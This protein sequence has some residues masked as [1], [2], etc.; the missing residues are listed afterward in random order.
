MARRRA[1]SGGARA[2]FA[3]RREARAPRGPRAAAPQARGRTRHRRPRSTR[4]SATG[5]ARG[6]RRRTR[7][8]RSCRSASL[9]S[10]ARRGGCS[11]PCGRCTWS[12]AAA[13]PRPRAPGSARETSWGVAPSAGSPASP[14]AAARCRGLSRQKRPP[15]RNLGMPRSCP[16]TGGHTA[17]SCQLRSRGG[18]GRCA[19]QARRQLILRLVCCPSETTSKPNRSNRAITPSESKSRCNRS[20]KLQQRSRRHDWRTRRRYAGGQRS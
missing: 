18:P 4:G 3:I 2:P 1:G 13:A 8:R 16:P 15:S 17:C 5:A 19:D 6:S 9:G 20:H 11:R 14:P 12:T 7:T 10:T